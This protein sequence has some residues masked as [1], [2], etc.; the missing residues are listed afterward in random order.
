MFDEAIIGGAVKIANA[1]LGKRYHMMNEPIK[2][3]MAEEL[4]LAAKDL[5]E[6]LEATK[7]Q[8]E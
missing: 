7:K 8:A 3:W 2:E 5:L 4:F 6:R 1:R